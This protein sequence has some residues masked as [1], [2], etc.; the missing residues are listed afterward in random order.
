MFVVPPYQ[1]FADIVLS[2][3]FA[4]VVFVVGGLVLIIAGNLRRWQLVNAP[5]FRVAHL[6]AIGVVV[7]EVWLGATC[8][9][10]TLEVWLR[11]KTGAT[12]Y[13]V[14]FIE[15]WLQRLL[16]YEAPSWVFTLGYS[17]FGMLVLA[18]WLYFPPRFKNRCNEGR[19]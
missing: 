6:G 15:H 12:T 1:L 16:F 17:V 18:A 19:I 13:S 14:G 7:T 2:A 10:T 3:H 4:V 9:L 11:A 8:P 5:W